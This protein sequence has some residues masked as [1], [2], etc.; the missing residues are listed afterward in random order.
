M[1]KG[2]KYEYIIYTVH[3]YILINGMWKG[4]KS[5]VKILMIECQIQCP[6]N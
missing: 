2:L 5:T 4:S 1:S 3:I 6:R